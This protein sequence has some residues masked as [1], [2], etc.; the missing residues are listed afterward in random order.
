MPRGDYGEFFI[1]DALPGDEI[2]V[3]GQ[4]KL[5]V[6][7]RAWGHPD[8][9]VPTKLE[10]VL[11]GE[12][13]RSAESTDLKNE[14]LSLDFEQEAGNG[15]WIAA[16]ATANDGTSAH[17]TPVYVVRKGLR[18]WKYQELEQ[19]LAKRRQSLKVVAQ[20]VAD[21]KQKVASGD[22]GG[23]RRYQQLVT[24]GSA[25]LERVAEAHAFY[26]DLEKIAVTERAFRRGAK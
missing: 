3:D 17:T 8:R 13:I 21:A 14:E 26:S 22:L 12:V 6:R 18:F 9:L 15:F 1:D 20:L 10:I 7:A 19:L 24:Q 2:V 23:D 25:L 11:H 16:R 5:R 4:R